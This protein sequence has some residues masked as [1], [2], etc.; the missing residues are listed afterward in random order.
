MIGFSF[1]NYILFH[2]LLTRRFNLM[3]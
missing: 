1:M 3:W 2:Y